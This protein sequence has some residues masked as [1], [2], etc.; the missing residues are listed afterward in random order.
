MIKLTKRPVPLRLVWDELFG[1]FGLGVYVFVVAV[2]AAL[3]SENK[4]K[5]CDGM[6]GSSSS[7]HRLRV[8]PV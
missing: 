6:R 1:F 7:M 5:L 8:V 2:S 3:P 4:K